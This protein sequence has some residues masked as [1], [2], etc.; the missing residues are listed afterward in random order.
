M[1]IDIRDGQQLECITCALCID[2]CDGVMD[3]LGRERGLISYATLS[4]YNANMSLATAGGTRPISPALVHDDQ[5][6]LAPNVAHFHLRKIFR[7]RTMLYLGAWTLV[8]ILLLYGLLSRDRLDVNVLHDRNPQFVILSDGSVRNGYTVKLLNKI[9]EP[10]TIMLTLQ[11]L[12]GAGMSIVGIDEPESR[13]FAIRVEPDR[14]KTLKV[15]VRLPK[16]FVHDEL[17]HFRFHVEDKASFEAAEY[18][19]SFEAPED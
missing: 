18:V 7:P 9:P 19:A 6:R 4:D 12:E 16:E 10:R 3:K 13:S 11:G 1:G 8:G 15:Y 5:G 2:A 17:E 14:L